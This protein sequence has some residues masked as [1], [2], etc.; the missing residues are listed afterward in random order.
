MLA[1]TDGGGSA[2]GPG[3]PRG[4][5]P[6]GEH[7]VIRLVL[8][9]S[10]RGHFHDLKRV[11]LVRRVLLA[12]HHQHVLEALVVFLA[13]RRRPVAEAVE[14]E[15]F[16]RRSDVAGVEALGALD[17]VGVEQDLRV[18]GVR[19][20][21]R[22]EAVLGAERLHERLGAG[23][24]QGPVPVGRAVDTLDVGAGALGHQLGVE[25]HDDLE[26]LAV[27]FLVAQAELHRLGQRV[28][29]VAAVVVQ[30]QHVGARVQHRGDVGR[31]VGLG[32]R[33]QHVGD[34]LPADRLGRG[35]QRRLL[36]PAPGV[37]GGQVIGLAVL[38]V[39]LFEHRRQRL[40]RHVGVEE[41]AEAVGLLVLAGGVVRV[42][43]AGHEDHAGFLAQALHGD[44]LGGGRA[45]RDHDRA[46]LLDH[47]LRRGAGLVGL[48]GGVGGGVGD[49]LAQDAG[50]V[51]RLR[52]E[53]RHH[54]AVAAAVQVL[55]RQLEGLQ[56]V[57]ALVGIG[58]G[59]RHVE[60]QRDGV[61]RRLVGEGRGARGEDRR[62]RQPGPGDGAGP[63]QAATGQVFGHQVLPVCVARDM[64]GPATPWIYRMVTD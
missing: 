8:D 52:R 34:G 11:E 46:V 3:A 58:A 12:L 25:R 64:R 24:L 49:L 29:H 53:G 41:V 62:Q 16:Q 7:R 45:A 35:L 37:V 21:R 15:P 39:G 54:A 4:G 19:G 32:Q 1:G 48:G 43:Q 44:R 30:E 36:G 33:R 13:V 56:F 47:R 59:Q 26:L 23:I 57:R 40:A 18:A 22:R 14:L 38:A 2:N 51:Q 27:H 17:G 10:A 55:D 9:L 63:Q 20:L 28:D 50:A 6:A 61:A 5:G 60:A 42:R 31:E